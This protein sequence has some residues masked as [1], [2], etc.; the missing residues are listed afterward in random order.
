MK[1]LALILLA[2]LFT[3]I[4]LNAQPAKV[5]Q[6]EPNDLIQLSEIDS[7]GIEKNLDI[8]AKAPATEHRGT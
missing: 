5:E 1:S 6:V 2:Q 7:S 3:H 8:V 4:N